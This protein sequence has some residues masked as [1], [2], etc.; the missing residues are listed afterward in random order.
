MSD[1][2]TYRP[3][4]RMFYLGLLVYLAA[5]FLTPV[6]DPVHQL[7]RLPGLA[8]LILVLIQVLFPK[9]RASGLANMIA[10]FVILGSLITIILINAL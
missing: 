1:S 3:M 10:F 8:I 9:F 7:F 2:R 4:D 5:Q 6:W